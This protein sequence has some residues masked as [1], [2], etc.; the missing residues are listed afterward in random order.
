MAY[1]NF[2][3]NTIHEGAVGSSQNKNAAFPFS[4]V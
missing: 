1:K 3:T 2:V 4:K